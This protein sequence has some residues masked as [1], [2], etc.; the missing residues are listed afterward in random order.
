MKPE[1]ENTKNQPDPRFDKLVKTLSEKDPMLW[2]KEW[3][4]MKEVENKAFPSGHGRDAQ[5]HSLFEKAKNGEKIHPGFFEKLQWSEIPAWAWT[6][7]AGV[8]FALTVVSGFLFERSAPQIVQNEWQIIHSSGKI[9]QFENGKLRNP[10]AGERL[11]KGNSISVGSG[12]SLVFADSSESVVFLTG[13]ALVNF[14]QSGQST[15][16]VRLKYGNLK[17]RGFAHSGNTNQISIETESAIYTKTGTTAALK[18][19]EFKE[20]LE[21]SE[22]QFQVLRK[23]TGEKIVL[24]PA[25]TVTLSRRVSGPM[26]KFKLGQKRIKELE[27]WSNDILNPGQLSEEESARKTWTLEELRG[28]YSSLQIVRFKNGSQR[29]G[30]VFTK[31]DAWYIHG[32]HGIEQFS[33]AE[34]DSIKSVE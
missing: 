11:P 25:E 5:L 15:L 22:G 28:L 6:V 7:A 10:E 4:R 23:S 29:T 13:P 16:K 18:A 30:F 34:V 32:V 26:R 24:D 19:T 1:N 33:F 31:S 3:R 27:N 9:R 12:G 8:F 20:T 14:S 2:P 21:V 17:L